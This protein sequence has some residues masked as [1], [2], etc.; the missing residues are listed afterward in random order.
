MI[1]GTNPTDIDTV[2]SFEVKLKRAQSFIN[3]FVNSIESRLDEDLIT[4][5]INK[6]IDELQKFEGKI[7]ENNINLLYI[8]SLSNG[9]DKASAKLNLKDR[10]RA[11]VIAA[12]NGEQKIV[13]N[14][15][16]DVKQGAATEEDFTIIKNVQNLAFIEAAGQGHVNTV[17]FLFDDSIESRSRAAAFLQASGQGKR[18]VTELILRYDELAAEKD[19]ISFFQKLAAFCTTTSEAINEDQ[20]TAQSYLCPDVDTLLW[21]S[22]R[23]S[24]SSLDEQAMQSSGSDMDVDEEAGM[25]SN[26]ASQKKSKCF[27]M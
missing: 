13:Q 25:E 7:S 20:K 3:L 18:Y 14:L 22:F 16:A 11:L 8:I 19:K 15:L 26:Q 1:V 12:Q 2:A 5:A 10:G 21:D 24:R 4:C 9:C 6:N 17:R 27:I 23:F